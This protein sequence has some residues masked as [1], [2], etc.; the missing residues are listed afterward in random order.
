MVSIK[1]LT[2]YFSEARRQMPELLGYSRISV[3]EFISRVEER[4]SLLSLS[5]HIIEDGQL[6][7]TYEFKH[8]TFQEYLA[9]LAA[10]QGYYPN[11]QEH[12]L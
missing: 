9:A 10:A 6:R 8:L 5:G 11:R 4:S 3:N 1:E 7:A 2:G 12:E